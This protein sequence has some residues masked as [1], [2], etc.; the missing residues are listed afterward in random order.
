[1]FFGRREAAAAAELRREVADLNEKLDA[2]LDALGITV[3]GTEV[4]LDPEGCREVLPEA[5]ESDVLRKAA[6][7]ATQA[8]RALAIAEKLQKPSATDLY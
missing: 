4:H 2:A 1:M 6:R 3:V 5:I 8:S 7:A